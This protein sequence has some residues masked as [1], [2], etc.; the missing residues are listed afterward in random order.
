MSV[1]TIQTTATNTI[2]NKTA[3]DYLSE[4]GVIFGQATRT[5][6][7]LRNRIGK[8][9]LK[10]AELEKSICKE[11]EK[12]FGISNSEAKNAYNKADAL[13]K[14]QSELVDLYIEDNYDRIKE[15][16]R[17][18]K[19]LEFKLDKAAASGQ[20]STVKKLKKKIHFKQQKINKLDAKILRLKESKATGH[21]TVTFG[22]SKLFEKQYRLEENGYKSK[23]EWLEDWRSA[24][25]NHSFFIGSKNYQGGNQLVRYDANLHTLTITVTPKLRGKYGD[26]VTL[27]GIS[28]SYGQEW[29]LT[30]I[31]PVKHTS[32][33]KGN[34][35]EK[36]ET[37]R[38]GSKQPV[39]YEIVNKDGKF[40]VN[41]TLETVDPVI[42]TSLENGALG[43][44]FN[45][46][47]I[48][49]TLIDRHGNLKRHGSIRI[50]VQDK[51]SA[52]TKDI[53]GKV[54]S[55]VARIALKYSVP[56]VI[57]DL[58]FAQKK[59][60]M[61]EKGAK[62]ARMLS[63]MAYSQFIQMIESR[64]IKSG[65]ELIKV[66]AAY[67]S[68]IGVTKYMAVYGLNSGCAAGMVIAR[69]GQGRTER[70]PKRLDSYFKKPEDKLKSGAWRKVA[71]AINICGG[72]NRH[73]FYKLG[74]KQA[75]TNSPLYSKLRQTKASSRR[76]TVQV[77]VTPHIRKNPRATGSISLKGVNP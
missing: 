10:E 14:S 77:L 51:R 9:Q 6:F 65:V 40:Y 41:A 67:T 66:D 33:R 47:S 44:D 59:A 2:Q 69:R 46:A 70:L 7:S 3:L 15:I 54:V 8:T 32:T 68:V 75:R 36:K 13:Y 29:L 23:E 60:S 19:K 73:K 37:S 62:Y 34:N 45:P 39:T 72:F 18:I 4:Y 55:E 49:W 74:I 57:E 76:D 25:Y 20:E 48:D 22:S 52:Q 1:V 11:L 5:A 17:T 12:R 31:E 56:V 53:I 61:K 71:K 16:R 43:I 42:Q 38:N 35:G 58:D 50:N 26:T 21:F 64:C 24:R 63:N 30:A 28:F 27:N